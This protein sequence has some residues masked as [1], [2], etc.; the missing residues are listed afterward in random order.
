MFG[1]FEVRGGN[2]RNDVVGAHRFVLV[3][4]RLHLHEVDHAL[5]AV[6]RPDRQLNRN[7]VALQLGR[8]LLEGPLEIGADAVHLVD[9]ADARHAVLVGLAPDGLRLRL[10]PGH[11]VEHGDGAVEH[12]Q[13]ALDFGG[14]VH[15]AGRI[16]DVLPV[17][18]PEAGRRGRRD[19]DAALLFLLHPVHDG[20]AVMDFT[21]LVRDPGVVQDPFRG[22]RLA[23][24]DVRHDADVPRLV[25]RYLPGH[26]CF[27]S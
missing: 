12:A 25:E 21:D 19:R 20:G 1:F 27:S 7:R 23:G 22:R 10:D 5:K 6:F 13:R 9:E 8:D 17:L 4:D 18:A 11:R 26:W 16:D 14:E 15:V 24:I 2:V 3:G